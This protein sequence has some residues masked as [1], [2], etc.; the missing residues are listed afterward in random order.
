MTFSEKMASIAQRQ[1]DGAGAA[2][3]PLIGAAG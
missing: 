1:G 2:A 3:A